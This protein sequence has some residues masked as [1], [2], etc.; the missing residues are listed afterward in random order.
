MFKKWKKHLDKGRKCGALFIDLSKAFDG[1]QYD[2]LLT[3]LNAYRFNFKS[4]KL[5]SAFG[6]GKYRTKTNSAYN[7]WQDL[8]IGAPQGSVLGPLLFTIYM[9][10]LFLSF[11]FCFLRTLQFYQR[12]EG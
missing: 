8:L 10:D 7:D 9:C 12:Q 2:L 11:F 3:K 4:V 6:E 5:I 1:L